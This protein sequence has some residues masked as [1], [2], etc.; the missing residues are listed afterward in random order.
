M[1]KIHVPAFRLIGLKLPKKTTNKDGQANIDCGSLWQ[2]FESEK[3]AARI[4]NKLG[5][6]VYAVYFEY[7]GDHTQ[8]Y[9]YFIGCKV[10]TDAAGLPGLDTL[11]ISSE[12]CVKIEAKGKMPD[13]VANAW[14]GIWNTVIDRAY[15]YDFEKYDD[16]S[17]DWSNAEVDIFVSVN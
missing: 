8:P 1:N 3:V 10:E 2:K 6:E 5:E 7:E 11:L 13:C 4:P 14:R 9:S 12:D 17:K 15:Q 16:R